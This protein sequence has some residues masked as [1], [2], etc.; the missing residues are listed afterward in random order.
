MEFIYYNIFIIINFIF[1]SVFFTNYIY[2]HDILIDYNIE[3]KIYIND[4]IYI[5]E[6]LKFML[7]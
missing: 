5:I 2:I 6:N 4:E 7:K 1:W 3:K